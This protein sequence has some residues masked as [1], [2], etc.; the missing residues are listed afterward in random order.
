MYHAAAEMFEAS[1]VAPEEYTPEVRIGTRVYR[2]RKV[3]DHVL[4]HIRKEED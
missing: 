1:A 3:D 2:I 4:P